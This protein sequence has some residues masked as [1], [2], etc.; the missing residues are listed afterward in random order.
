MLVN[1]LLVLVSRILLVKT[2]NV[3][4]HDFRKGNRAVDRA[5]NSSL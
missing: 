3:K 5:G 2:G 1:L 4:R